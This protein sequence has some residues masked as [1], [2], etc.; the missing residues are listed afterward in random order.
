MGTRL[1]FLFSIGLLLQACSTTPRTEEK[2]AQ[3][4]SVYECYASHTDKDSVFLRLSFDGHQVKGDL[5]Y[6]LFEKDKNHGVIEGTVH[7]DTIFAIY[8]FISEGK[9]SVREVAFLR[10]G[11][12]TLVEGFAPMNEDGTHFKNKAELDFTGTMLQSERCH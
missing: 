8:K 9:A 12:T 10:Q 4:N 11:D 3:Q 1:L 6:K 2:I 5:T 7:G